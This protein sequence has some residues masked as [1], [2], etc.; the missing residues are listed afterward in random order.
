MGHQPF[1]GSPFQHLT[2]LTVKKL[3][4]IYN[5]KLCAIPTCPAF[6]DQEVKTN[7]SL[8]S[9]PPQDVAESREVSSQPSL[10]QARQPKCPPRTGLPA[11]L[12][13]FLPSSG[14]FQVPLYP[15]Y[16]V[17]PRTVHGT[18]GKATSRL[19]IAGEL[20]LWTS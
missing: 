10:L 2:I 12:P 20:L 16:T 7:T 6:S 14:H 11:I 13:A 8:W 15:I 17:E 19:N 4:A 1:L 18:Q 9:S 3:F 5:P